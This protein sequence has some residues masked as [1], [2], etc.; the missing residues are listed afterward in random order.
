MKLFA[1]TCGLVTLLLA[2]CCAF[3][4]ELNNFE[5]E[6]LIKRNGKRLGVAHLTLTTD[7]EG[8]VQYE[9]VSKGDRG[10][11]KLLG[12]KFTES[13]TA[14]INEGELRPISYEYRQKARFRSRKRE[15]HF[16]WE[17]MRADGINRKDRWS[18]EFPRGVYDRRL[19]ELA[20]AL[21]VNAGKKNVQ[22]NVVSKGRLKQ[23][24]FAVVGEEPIDV[25]LG[26]FDTTVVNRV[27][28]NSDKQIKAY[29]TDLL[30]L[31]PARIVYVDE[32]ETLE[33]SVV[34]YQSEQ[35]ASSGLM[36]RD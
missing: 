17:A 24:S 30:P 19:V 20:L 32:D 18:L 33:L 16:D 6:Y 8:R 35:G 26:R 10:L 31:A 22:Y 28:Q 13:S 25:P 23:Y 3:A 27:K 34:S 5:A 14:Q 21:D 29:Y 1:K 36:A 9:L 2:C 15:A 4:G 11:A 12:F 7:H